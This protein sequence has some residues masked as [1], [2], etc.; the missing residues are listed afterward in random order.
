M[1][2]KVDN[3]IKIDFK[4]CIVEDR[5]LQIQPLD[6]SNVPEL[7]NVWTIDIHPQLSKSFIELVKLNTRDQDPIPLAHCK[8]IRKVI[9]EEGNN[10]LRCIICSTLMYDNIDEVRELIKFDYEN[11][12]SSNKVPKRGPYDKDLVKEWSEKYWPL[13][14]NGNPND[15]IL[16]DSEFKMDEINFYLKIIQEESKRIGKESGSL[17]IVSVFVDPK[18]KGD[19][20]LA[21][22]Q[23]S[24]SEEEHLSLEID[25]SIMVGINKVANTE[26]K[27]RSLEDS[28]N[29]PQNYLCLDFDVYTTHEPC[30]MC[31]MALIHSRIKRCIFIEQMPRTGALMANSGNSYCMHANK[32]LNSKYEVYKWIG[33]EYKVPTINKNIC[34]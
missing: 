1:V 30:S 32:K 21:V 19:F 31:S 33:D 22:D 27:R 3:K 28:N 20:I 17:P 16:N 23:R 15:Q 9:N 18:F 8:R 11:L 25:H 29:V 24:H 34:V 6:I 26:K 14:W 7:C 4:R 2:K 5:L 12:N 13:V 10:L